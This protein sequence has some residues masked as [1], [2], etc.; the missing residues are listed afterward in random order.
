MIPR[1]K[2]SKRS[3]SSCADVL[4]NC[5]LDLI[6]LKRKADLVHDT[7]DDHQQYYRCSEEGH[8]QLRQGYEPARELAVQLEDVA[9][10]LQR[11][12][13]EIRPRRSKRL[14]QQSH[15]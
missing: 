9:E 14:K 15:Q 2:M 13:Q 11:F 12:A 6:E 3:W 10:I 1:P 8:D 5:V 4:D 7:I